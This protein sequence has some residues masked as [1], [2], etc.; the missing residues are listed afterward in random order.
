MTSAP[1]RVIAVLEPLN[2][3]YVE[4]DKDTEPN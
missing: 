3:K 4:E 1:Y 2:K